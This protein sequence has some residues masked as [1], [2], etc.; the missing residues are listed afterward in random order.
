MT[1]CRKE[2]LM[3]EANAQVAQLILEEFH[4]RFYENGHGLGWGLIDDA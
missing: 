1:G 3:T 2:N 4:H